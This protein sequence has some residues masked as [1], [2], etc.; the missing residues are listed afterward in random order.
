MFVRPFDGAQA[1]LTWAFFGLADSMR[2]WLTRACA[3]AKV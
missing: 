3:S 1:V 2:V